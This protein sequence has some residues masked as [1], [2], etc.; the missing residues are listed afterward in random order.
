MSVPGIK[1]IDSTNPNPKKNK[2]FSDIKRF[3]NSVTVVTVL[4]LLTTTTACRKDESE[5]E[6]PKPSP[7]VEVTNN[8]VT[9]MNDAT[10]YQGQEVIGVTES[11][12]TV[13]AS[14]TIKDLSKMYVEISVNHPWA[15]DLVFALQ[16]PDGTKKD[17]VYRISCAGVY[18]NRYTLKFNSLFTNVLECDGQEII[19]GN[20]KESKGDNYPLINLESIFSSFNGK[21]VNG[22]WKLIFT[23][24]K[25]G[26]RGTLTKWKLR[27]EKG[28]LN[29]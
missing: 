28:A 29:Q 20:Y 15:E 24:V 27:F 14:G 25:V 17:F 26:S 11:S 23:D 10:L 12:I 3:G 22:T 7:Q 1:L 21:Q 9:L 8:D 4:A 18:D 2:L 19:T 5:P 6:P 16:S 13:P